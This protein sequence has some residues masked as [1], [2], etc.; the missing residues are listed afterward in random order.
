MCEGS[1]RSIRRCKD[2]KNGGYT[3]CEQCE[4]QKGFYI[5]GSTRMLCFPPLVLQQIGHRSVNVYSKIRGQ[6]Y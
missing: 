1:G 2:Q 5:A 6:L 4:V 3:N